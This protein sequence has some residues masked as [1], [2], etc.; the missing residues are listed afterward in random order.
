M[1]KVYLLVAAI[2][3]VAISVAGCTK[4]PENSFGGTDF[5]RIS[6]FKTFSR[7]TAGTSTGE[8]ILAANEAR[9]YALFTNDSDTAV[10]LNLSASST[11]ARYT[12]RLNA[13][14]GTYELNDTNLYVGT[15]DA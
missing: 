13:N 2:F 1:K 12:V 9:T 7:V 5:N 14:G 11:L 15:V 10:Y 8:L 3:V 6:E 4:L